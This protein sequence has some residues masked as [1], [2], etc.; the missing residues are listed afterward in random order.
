M[1]YGRIPGRLYYPLYSVYK[2][3]FI[4]DTILEDFDLV[5]EKFDI[6]GDRAC[7]IIFRISSKDSVY[8]INYLL[9]LRERDLLT[10]CDLTTVCGLTTCG[11]GT[12]VKFSLDLFNNWLFAVNKVVSDWNKDQVEKFIETSK[13]LGSYLENIRKTQYYKKGNYLWI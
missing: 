1:I 4:I 10:V 12:D 13:L 8:A 3:H 7:R 9:F 5:K 6:P 11:S 2:I